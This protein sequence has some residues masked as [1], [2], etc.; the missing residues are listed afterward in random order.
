MEQLIENLAICRELIE[1][2]TPE[3]KKA[4]RDAITK[5]FPKHSPAA[6]S[7]ASHSEDTGVQ[8]TERAVQIIF[9]VLWQEGKHQKKN[10]RRKCHGF[11]CRVTPELAK[12]VL[13][14]MRREGI[15]SKQTL[16][17]ELLKGWVS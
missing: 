3:Q 15:A 16:L 6:F 11:S 8:F 7:L 13:T 9:E 1:R 12:A 17:E 10:S 4:C 14:K 2:A 5:E